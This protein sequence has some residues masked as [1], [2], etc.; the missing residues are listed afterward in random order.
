MRYD[1]DCG[2]SVHVGFVI[3]LI[4]PADSVRLGLE[5]ARADGVGGNVI[6]R[7]YEAVEDAAALARELDAVCQVLLFTGRFPYALGRRQPGLTAELRY[8]PHSGADLYGAILRLLQEHG[9]RL[10]RVSLDTIEPE[11]AQEA[12]E[13]LGLEPPLHVLPLD[14]H[15]DGT[16]VASTA[17]LVAFH[18]ERQR[19]DDVEVSLTCVGSVFREL[20]AAGI[21]ALRIRHTKSVMREA[22]REARLSERLAI[23][24]AAQPAV[25]LVALP[26]PATED[27]SPYETQRRQRHTRA[28]VT[29]MAE[30]LQGRLADVDDDRAIIYT[31][32]GTI[33]A[34][35]SRRL[36]GH[37]GPLSAERRAEGL[38]VGVGLGGTV[39]TAEA[40]ARL[41]LRM[42]ERD[43]DL[44]VGFPDGEVLRLSADRRSSLYRLRETHPSALRLA[45]ELGIGPLAFTRLV[46]ALQQLDAS[47]VT[48][49]DLARAYGIEVR[50]ARRLITSLQRAGIAIRLGSQ[51]GPRAGRP[52]GVYRVDLDRLLGTTQASRA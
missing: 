21:P 7:A 52:Q 10:P 29:D 6:G 16:M 19:A 9:C 49:A 2:H 48:A 36:A 5:V 27:G 40:N 47:A 13:D 8:V 30:R 20:D 12:F 15:A 44:H 32:R 17:D 37:H 18:R 43:G 45:H 50:S 4:G 25:V 3:G 28:T 24:E 39:A 31:S 1:A 41:A 34:A 46:R 23:T 35:L 33:E 14:L 26:A 42:G 38:R 51:G 22:L 11:I